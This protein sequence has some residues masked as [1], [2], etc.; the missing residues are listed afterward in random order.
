MDSNMDQQPGDPAASQS[1]PA[2]R[3]TSAI[4]F[5]GVQIPAAFVGLATGL[6]HLVQLRPLAILRTFPGLSGSPVVSLHCPSPA[7]ARI[8]GATSQ[9]VLR[10]RVADGV[11]EAELRVGAED[12]LELCRELPDG[13]IATVSEGRKFQ[14]WIQTQ[15]PSSQDGLLTGFERSVRASAHDFAFDSQGAGGVTLLDGFA[16]G[17]W[18]AP[19]V[20]APPDD[21]NTA[22]VVAWRQ[23]IHGMELDYL[24]G[25]VGLS[26]GGRYYFT[27]WDDYL[28]IDTLTGEEMRRE[29]ILF[30]VRTAALSAD[31]SMLLVAGESA[32]LACVG[33][34]GEALWRRELPRPVASVALHDSNLFAMYVD[35]DGECG[36]VSCADG[37][38][39]V[40]PAEIAELLSK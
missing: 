7:A 38:T 9:R 15:V 26:A 36:A 39:M 12:H 1:A 32:E 40:Q 3:I 24:V 21:R 28:V 31:G 23:P 11:A 37:R 25:Y 29:S 33:T 19:S 4:P 30:P 22:A 16:Y 10:W 14:H 35:C 13:S 5:R 8:L 20:P 18:N 34:N 17:R 2:I 27:Y 6:V